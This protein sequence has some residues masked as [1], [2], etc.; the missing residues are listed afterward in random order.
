MLHTSATAPTVQF[1]FANS[2]SKQNGNSVSFKCSSYIRRGNEDGARRNCLC[3][4]AM[5]APSIASPSATVPHRNPHLRQ[6]MPIGT[7]DVSL[8]AHFTQRSVSVCGYTSLA[9][10]RAVA[11]CACWRAGVLTVCFVH[12]LDVATLHCFVA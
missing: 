11:S 4:C 12:W 2:K 7:S 1:R 3:A 10:P 9:A 8:A 5:V 6:L